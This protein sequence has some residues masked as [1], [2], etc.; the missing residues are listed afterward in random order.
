MSFPFSARARISAAGPWS[1]SGRRDGSALPSGAELSAYLKRDWHGCDETELT[2][3]AQW[4]LEMGG[5]G[6]LFNA[7]H[8]LFNRNY[9][10]TALHTFLASIPALLAAKK[11]RRAIS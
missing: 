7:L 1:R 5:S 10:P 6:E 3:V 11:F 4:V 9:P 2:R 8:E